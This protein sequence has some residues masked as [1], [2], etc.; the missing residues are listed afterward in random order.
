MNLSISARIILGF[1]TALLALLLIGTVAYRN[2]ASLNEDVAAVKHTLEVLQVNERLATRLFEAQS[3]ARGYMLA[4]DQTAP[5]RFATTVEEVR[6]ASRALRALT[7][8]N[9]T[10]Q[11]RLD[12]LEPL[13]E[14]RIAAARELMDSRGR[15]SLDLPAAVVDLVQ[16][17]TDLTGSIDSVADAVEAEERRLLDIRERQSRAAQAMT[18]STLIFGTLA[19]FV[20][21]ALVSLL[22]TRSIREQ[23]QGLLASAGRI[24]RGDYAERAQV[25]GRDE[26]GQL[27]G[28]FNVMAEQVQQR[29]EASVA[30]SW[31]KSSLARLSNLFE[32]ERRLDALGAKLLA[33]LASLIDA[34]HAA[35]YLRTEQGQ[36]ELLATYAA[37][38]APK[39]IAPGQGLIGQALRDRHRLLLDQVPDDYIK[40]GSALGSTRPQAVAI[41]P[42]L[43]AGDVKAVIELAFLKPCTHLQLTF[44]DRLAESLGLVVTTIQASERTARLLVESEALTVELQERSDKLRLSEQLLKEQ[45]EELRQTNEELE[46]ANEELQQANVEMEERAALLAAQKLS[47]EQS[48]HEVDEARRAL[49]RQSAQLAQTSKYKSQFLANMSHE[50]RTPLNSL[51]ILSKVLAENHTANL[52][53]KQVQHA[54]TIHSAGN[55]LLELINEVLDLS[56][57]EAGAIDLEVGEV[58]LDSLVEII[59]NT[60]R[61]IAEQKRLQLRARTDAASGDVMCTDMRRLQQIVKNLLSNALKFTSAGAVE[62]TIRPASG[63]W[64][65]KSELLEAAPVVLAFEVKDTGIGIPEDRLQRIF[66]AFHQGDAGT[67]RKYGGTGLGL[68][69]SRELAQRLGG[70]LDVRSAVGQGSVF[71]LYL[72]REVTSEQL[73]YVAGKFE[74]EATGAALAPA[75]NVEARR[76]PELPDLEPATQADDRDA[77]QPGDLTLLAIEDDVNFA[78]ILAEFARE[79]GFKVVLAQTAGGGLALA[80]R[81]RPTA[82]TLDLRLPDADGRMVLDL[83]KHDP[84]TRH[85]PVHVISVDAVRE[86]M[87]RAGAVSFL[88]K[89]VTKHAI[90]AALARTVDFVK[91]PMKNLLIVEDDDV[92]RHALV[93]LIGASDVNTVAVASADAALEQLKSLT[94]DC[95]VVDLVLP[96]R[97]GTEL[98]QTIHQQLRAEAPPIIVYTA[99]TL[100]RQEETELR[101]LSEAIVLKDARSPERLLDETAL[102]LHRVQAQLPEPKRKLL[103]QVQRDD[104]TLSGRK[105]LIVDDDVRNIFAITT[106]LESYRMEVIYAESGRAGLELLEATQDVAAVLMDVMMPEMDGFEATQRIRRNARFKNLPVIMV[107]A[108]AMKGDREKCL[109]AGASDYITKPVDMDQLRSLLRVWLY[110]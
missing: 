4:G 106:A 27:A 93:E 43:L 71:T 14:Q 5:G 66:E 12:S 69:I 35:M 92:Q 90:D 46:Q 91:R 30:D 26:I 37:D 72:P 107:T 68:S 56:K 63:G 62:L 22:L 104:P 80:R 57:I 94:F 29:Q 78:Q 10:Q 7:Q 89:P 24:A 17:G 45:Q 36:L 108:K 6:R 101:R 32:A 96:D 23:M 76:M 40:I 16:N 67:A 105:V 65:E 49:E 18:S 99:K 84:A 74:T 20:L 15:S 82:I 50:L 109:A 88:Q 38:A 44:L 60:F 98:I 1:A 79:K 87:L 75:A 102:F 103:E 73:A 48:N 70:V 9:P 58:R 13:V 83:L 77:L 47:L 33:E 39:L 31:L 54:Q 19:A 64:R 28:A 95:I 51:L 81:L 100:T 59:E 97:S 86:R 11:R 53:P 2:L 25:R 110:R 55:D 41:V 21:V 52:T 3:I 8:D 61:P 42:A 85:I 34:Q